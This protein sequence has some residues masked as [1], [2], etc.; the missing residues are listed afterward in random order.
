MI[1]LQNYLTLRKATV[2]SIKFCPFCGKN[3]SATP[4]CAYCG[5]DLRA[6]IQADEADESPSDNPSAAPD[7]QTDSDIAALDAIF[8][9]A[10]KTPYIAALEPFEVESH[11]NGKYA[12]VG[13]KNRHIPFIEI[14]DCVEVI[15]KGAFEGCSAM[16]ITLPTSIV[17]IDS[18]AFAGC[19]NLV[20]IKG[21]GSHIQFIADEAF[22]DCPN[23]EVALP[24]KARLGKDVIRG[25]LTEQRLEAE[26]ARKAEE[27]RLAEEARKAEEAKKAFEA[28]C[29]I[30]DGVLEKYEG[31]G[32]NVVIPDSITSIGEYA[33]YDCSGLTSI[34]ISNR[35][36][37]IGDWAF[38]YCE[39]LASITIP[40]SVTS[41]EDSAFYNCSSLTSITIPS[42]FSYDLGHICIYTSRT[43][44]TY[45]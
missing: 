27:A 17:L 6:F 16:E 35:V 2:M 13:L 44:V 20:A 19:P 26:K 3:W 42:R 10:A 40:N 34:T 24:E 7:I 29:D 37:S 4:F 39:N 33:F 11:G 43:R 32:G 21:L 41:I 45:I 38:G 9:E 8:T 5:K 28:V 14:P 25:T 18:R 30:S 12:I 23:L 1:H 36:T 31:V 22:A 15:G